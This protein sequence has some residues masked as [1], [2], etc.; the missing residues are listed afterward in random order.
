MDEEDVG[1]D[2]DEDL[3]V[4]MRHVVDKVEGYTT[5]VEGRGTEAR[6]PAIVWPS[7]WS[8]ATT[9]ACLWPLSFKPML[10]TLPLC[11]NHLLCRLWIRR[12][13]S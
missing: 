12:T 1:D 9:I 13:M 8:I 5:I 6:T 2:I 7:I 3:V 10:K 11:Q 4:K